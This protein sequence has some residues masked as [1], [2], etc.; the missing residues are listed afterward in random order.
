MARARGIYGRQES[1]I[2]GFGGENWR[3]RPRR[4]WEDNIK[5]DLD[6]GWE[7]MEWIVLAEYRDR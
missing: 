7:G 2:E 3:K 4:K 6:E 1:S 5:M